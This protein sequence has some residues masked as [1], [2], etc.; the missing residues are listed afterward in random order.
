MYIYYNGIFTYIY[1][2]IYIRIIVTVQY[3][4]SMHM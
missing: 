1:T 2:Y 4:I 3:L